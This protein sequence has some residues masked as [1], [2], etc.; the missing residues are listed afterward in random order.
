MLKSIKAKPKVQFKVAD[1][2]E[3]YEMIYRIRK[4]V[5]GQEQGYSEEC[6]KLNRQENQ[7]Y[8]L[9]LQDNIPVGTVTV[10]VSEKAGSL[11]LDKYYDL[12]KYYHKYGR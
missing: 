11:D 5:F 1:C 2:K 7:Y 10:E 9:C 4:A 12:N 8:I 3:D 6:L